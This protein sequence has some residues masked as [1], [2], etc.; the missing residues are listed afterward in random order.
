MID[1]IT[2]EL[3]SLKKLSSTQLNVNKHWFLFVVIFVV[4][5]ASAVHPEIGI[6]AT[7]SSD[8]SINQSIDRSD[9]S[10][11]AHMPHFLNV[12]MLSNLQI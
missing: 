5:E 12:L 3:N 6:V 8:K 11:N 7:A 10:L 4:P 1:S 9:N 2:K